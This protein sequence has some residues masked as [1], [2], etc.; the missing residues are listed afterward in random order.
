MSTSSD[1]VVKSEVVIT[2]P[3][4]LGELDTLILQCTTIPAASISW[5]KQSSVGVRLLSPTQR[6][7][8]ST[9][10]VQAI[11]G[12]M[13]TLGSVTITAITEIDAGDYLCEALSGSESIP[14]TEE[15]NISINGEYC[16]YNIAAIYTSVIN[17]QFL[18]NLCIM[19]VRNECRA[20][21]HGSTPCQNGG[22]C[23]DLVKNYLCTCS[24]NFE[25]KNCQKE[26]M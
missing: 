4:S 7:S 17:L 19:I 2:G 25:G 22:V 9:E 6:I 18:L 23:T 20:D 14:A 11:D 24:G 8:F 12:K 26:G 5:L 3:N 13:A 21:D 1:Y 10:K 16:S 15:I